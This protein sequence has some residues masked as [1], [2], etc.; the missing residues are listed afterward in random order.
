MATCYRHPQR[1]TNVSCANCERPICPDCMTVTP[2]GMRCPE[3]ARERTR[4]TTGVGSA[5][6]SEAPVTFGLIAI[7][8][9]AF[10]GIVAGGGT[11]GRGGGTVTI[12]GGLFAPYVADGQAYRIITSAFLHAGIFHLAVNMFVLFILGRLLEPAIGSLRFAGIYGVAV[13]GGSFGAL[14]LDPNALTV[15]AS[16]GIFGLMAA[17][18]LIARDRGLDQLSQQIGLFIVLNLV[19]TFSIPQIS[20]GGHIGGLIGGG[21]AAI[22]VSGLERRRIAN[23]GALEAVALVGLGAAAIAGALL[24]AASA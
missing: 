6:G 12:E 21:I 14:L 13:L 22:V 4:V 15:G 3:C 17:T 5:G 7:C 2:V 23:R 19:I 16:G 11:L 8:V 1:E 24:A 20:V 9:V 10:L 18:F